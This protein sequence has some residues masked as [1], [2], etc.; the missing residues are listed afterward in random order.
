MLILGNMDDDE[1]LKAVE[2]HRKSCFR[3]RHCEIC[4]LKFALTGNIIDLQCDICG[5]IG[6]WDDFK[7]Y[8]CIC[9][10]NEISVCKECITS[11][12]YEIL[13]DEDHHNEYID[14]CCPMTKAAK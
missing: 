13:D 9:L 2:E 8:I 1:L 11:I 7:I 4:S 14:I 10:T 5:M 3:K 6:S 12:P